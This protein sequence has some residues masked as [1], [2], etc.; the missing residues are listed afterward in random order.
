MSDRQFPIVHDEIVKSIPWAVL[1]PHEAQAIKNHKCPL[2][3][4][5]AMGGL[6]PEEVLAIVEGRAWERM[7][8]SEARQKL[9]DYVAGA[10]GK[11][12]TRPD[13]L[14]ADLE[15]AIA[16]VRQMRDDQRGVSRW[17]FNKLLT[18]LERARGM[19]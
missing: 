7:G 16:I 10:T 5:A 4:L 18:T 6:S 12:V 13:T 1:E 14:A 8:F 15:A 2:E 11:P 17:K 19:I 3:K 9:L